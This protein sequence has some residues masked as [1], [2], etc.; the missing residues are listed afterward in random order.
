MSNDYINVKK[1]GGVLAILILSIL[2][3]SIPDTFHLYH[4][5]QRFF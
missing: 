5:Y 3:N 4:F 1:Q 2:F